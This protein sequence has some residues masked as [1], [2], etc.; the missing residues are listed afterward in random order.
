MTLFIALYNGRIDIRHIVKTLIILI[1]NYS[2]KSHI[3]YC[4]KYCNDILSHTY[5]YVREG[6]GRGVVWGKKGIIS[7]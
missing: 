2:Y 6:G 3:R 7:F 1:K 4:T 5:V